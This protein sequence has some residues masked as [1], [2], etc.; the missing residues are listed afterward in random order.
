MSD[1]PI[2]QEL[3]TSILRAD[4]ISRLAVETI[5][6]LTPEELDE[7]LDGRDFRAAVREVSLRKWMEKYVYP[8]QSIVGCL[9]LDW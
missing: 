6:H 3:Y 8:Y 2:I 4:S 7:L 9:P 1:D 5:G